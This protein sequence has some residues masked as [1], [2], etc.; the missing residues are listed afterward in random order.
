M[1]YVGLPY[2]NCAPSPAEYESD[3]IDQRMLGLYYAAASSQYPLLT[4]PLPGC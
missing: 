1:L 4:V 3:A 2:A